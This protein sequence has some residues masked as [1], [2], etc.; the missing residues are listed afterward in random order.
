M[1]FP[2]PYVVLSQRFSE[3]PEKDARGNPVKKWSNPFAQSVIAFGPPQSSE[4]KLAGHDRVVVELELFVPPEFVAAH[5]DKQK[6]PDGSVWSV[7]GAIEDY[8]HGPWGFA[9]GGVVNLKRVEG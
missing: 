4:P 5:Q 3:G 9:P 7:L 1:R 2:T 6:L 8:T